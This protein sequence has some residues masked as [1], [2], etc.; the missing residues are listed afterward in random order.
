MPEEKFKELC[1]QANQK[2]FKFELRR[3]III[4]VIIFGLGFGYYYFFDPS[5][6]E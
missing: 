4:I 5:G 3:A 6:H 2:D 1:S